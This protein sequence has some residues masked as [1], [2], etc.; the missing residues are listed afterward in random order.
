MI[1]LYQIDAVW[2]QSNINASKAEVTRILEAFERLNT[3]THKAPLEVAAGQKVFVL[4]SNTGDEDEFASLKEAQ[5]FLQSR[6]ED[7][8]WEPEY[9]DD[10]ITVIIGREVSIEAKKTFS[11]KFS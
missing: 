2:K 4:D 5:E 1:T 10:Y 3:L 11:L 7:H 6:S 8:D 9:V